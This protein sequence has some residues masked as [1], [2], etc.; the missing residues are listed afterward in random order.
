MSTFYPDLTLPAGNLVFLTVTLLSQKAAA[1]GEG[2][3]KAA[4]R[5]LLIRSR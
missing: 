2:R 4:H 1:S 3:A 5:F